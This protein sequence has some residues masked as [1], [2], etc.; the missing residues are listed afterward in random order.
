MSADFGALGVAGAVA[1]VLWPLHEA[2]TPRVAAVLETEGNAARVLVV[3]AL[4]LLLLLLALLALLAVALPRRRRGGGSV[5]SRMRPQ[6][7][8]AI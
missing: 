4:L 5:G 3:A 6:N 7:A 1:A 8:N 2:L